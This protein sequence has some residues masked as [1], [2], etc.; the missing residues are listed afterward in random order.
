[1]AP[2]EKDVQKVAKAIQNRIRMY[3]RGLLTL[4]EV[5]IPEYADYYCTLTGV[6][7]GREFFLYP[8]GEYKVEPRNQFGSWVHLLVIYTYDE[9][10]NING[11][12]MYLHRY[13]NDYEDGEFMIWLPEEGIWVPMSE[14]M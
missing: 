4:D 2:F 13:E 5:Q 7:K 11:M 9:K 14:I 1:M 8:I 3:R 10:G 6:Y 12:E